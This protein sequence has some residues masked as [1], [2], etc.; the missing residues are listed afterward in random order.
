M[1]TKGDE[2]ATLE[3]GNPSPAA[4]NPPVNPPNMTTPP[5][6]TMRPKTYPEKGKLM[7]IALKIFTLSLRCYGVLGK[8]TKALYTRKSNANTFFI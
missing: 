1:N 2:F 7:F 3:L 6:Y 4:Y 5:A 8:L